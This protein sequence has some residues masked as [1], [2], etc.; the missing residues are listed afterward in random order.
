MENTRKNPLTLKVLKGLPL[1]C[2]GEG[3]GFLRALE[4]YCYMKAMWTDKPMPDTPEAR[5]QLATESG[6]S[7]KTIKR[8][9]ARLQELGLI[10]CQLYRGYDACSWDKL[11]ERF[12]IK[13]A[14][15]YHIQNKKHIRLY[16]ILDKKVESEKQKQCSVACNNRVKFNT[17]IRQS[18]EE[19]AG[20]FNRLHLA[21]HQLQLLLNG[22]QH[23]PDDFAYIFNTRYR[24]QYKNADDKK[25]R[26]DTA[27]SSRTLTKL[28]GYKGHG[29]MAYKK[30][31]WQRLGLC[32]VFSR[33]VEVPNGIYTT[34]EA[35][36]HRLGFMRFDRQK[37]VLEL[38]M[39]DLIVDAPIKALD[40]RYEAVQQYLQ[41]E[42][43]KMIEKSRQEGQ[44]HA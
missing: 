11:R 14:H 43:E 8:R 22:G 5:Q 16:D 17:Y 28:Y 39:P 30:R 33:R 37:G 19:V 31:K 34:V 24:G 12:G 15:F 3:P 18:Y 20:K 35:R 36:K 41:A 38:I 23:Y 1:A 13:H 4:T 21:H 9:L 2:A 6:R 32:D 25:L 42:R 7:V 29:T 27:L 26:G 10:T 40:E 44:R